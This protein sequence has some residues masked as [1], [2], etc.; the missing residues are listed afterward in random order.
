MKML[1][2]QEKILHPNINVKATSHQN[3]FEGGD[4]GGSPLLPLGNTMGHK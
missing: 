4:I 3:R 1:K 2:A